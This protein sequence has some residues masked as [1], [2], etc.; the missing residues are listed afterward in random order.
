MPEKLETYKEFSNDLFRVIVHTEK[1]H[2]LFQ[3]IMNESAYAGVK[4]TIND[5]AKGL[6]GKAEFKKLIKEFQTSFNSSFWELYLNQAF[7]DLGFEIDYQYDSPDFHLVHPSGDCLNV[8][9]V[10]ANNKDHE[11]AH[12]YEPTQVKQA[13]QRER[14][15]FLNQATIKSIGKL[16]DKLDLFKAGGK[17]YPYSALAHVRSYDHFW[18]MT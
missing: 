16:K 1:Q 18:C 4:E 7:C 8:E 10:T 12:Y 15:D 13:V 5:W 6:D 9:A 17:K 11:S 14:D 3:R 2:P